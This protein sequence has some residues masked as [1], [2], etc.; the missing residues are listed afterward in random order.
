MDAAPTRLLLAGLLAVVATV[1]GCASDAQPK[2]VDPGRDLFDPNPGR[3][4]QAV[5]VV[6][7]DQDRTQLPALVE[8]LE[9]RDPSVRM[10]ANR[11]LEDM[12]GRTTGYRAYDP[13]GTRRP[14][15]EEWRAYLAHGDTGFP[16]PD[17]GEGS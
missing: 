6:A 12:T 16:M 13:P 14:Y 17:G 8:L 15:V 5:A 7:S 10:A 4:L 11:T 9:D 2:P 1:T 3:R